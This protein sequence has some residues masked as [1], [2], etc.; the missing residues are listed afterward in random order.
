MLS[1][2]LHSL[3]LRILTPL[4]LPAEKN[5]DKIVA[6]LSYRKT[7]FPQESPE[8]KEHFKLL[9][10]DEKANLGEGLRRLYLKLHECSELEKKSYNWQKW[11]IIIGIIIAIIAIIVS[12]VVS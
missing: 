8:F 9:D 10:T 4:T 7:R 6:E 2:S 5:S 1:N 3:L 12:I 11:G